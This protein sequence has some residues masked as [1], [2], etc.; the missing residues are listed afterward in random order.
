MQNIR[1]FCTVK[2]LK[3]LFF[4]TTL[5]IYVFLTV[6]VSANA[7]TITNVK[8][9]SIEISLLTCGPGREAYSL[10]GHTAIRF[11][12]Y[13][14]GED[15]A[16]N[17]GMFSFSQ[18]YFVLRFIFGLTDYEM[19]IVPFEYFKKE[20]QAENRYVDEQVLNLTYEEKISIIAAIIENYK[21][22][23]RVYRY[24]FY[25]NNC[26]TRARDILISNIN[27]NIEY[28]ENKEI[29]TFRDI[30]HDYTATNPWSRFGNDLLL[31]IGSDKIATQKEQQFIPLN[32]EKDFA[33]AQ[34]IDKNGNKRPLVK[35][36]NEIIE[37]QGKGVCLSPLAIPFVLIEIFQTI[38][39][40]IIFGILLV[41]I[42]F[43]EYKHAK[44]FWMIDAFI[45]IVT[46]L[47]GIILTAM[48]F[49]EH[50][51]VNLNFQIL[52]LNPLNLILLYP[53]LKQLKNGRPSL[54]IRVWCILLVA[55]LIIGLWQTYAEGM[56]ILALSLLIRYIMKEFKAWK[57]QI[58]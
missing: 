7:D 3:S 42:T 17:Y 10:Y 48:I 18:K 21:P 44:R 40:F 30:I 35:A 6:T 37:V 26:T 51:T 32:L 12:N 49:S 38:F 54:W 20:Y 19:G 4:R 47:C 1:Y 15:F 2:R 14:T 25:Y 39:I 22:Q 23:N 11:T 16:V 43:Y 56:N 5:L 36:T 46:G 45:L 58:K 13:T 28:A 57:R 24:N 41:I 34:I 31:G 52:L 9:D 29:K 33:S 53:T 50:P 27:G 55:F 8:Q